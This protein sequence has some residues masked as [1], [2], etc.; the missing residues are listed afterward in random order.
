MLE[1]YKTNNGI[2]EKIDKPEKDAWINL[3]APTAEEIG[4]V[5]DNI[6]ME[7]TFIYAALDEEETSHIECE[8]GCTLV[9]VDIPY[10]ISDDEKSNSTKY[11]TVNYTTV[12]LGIILTPD[13]I[14]T[15]CLKENNI[16]N[17]FAD[18]KVKP[19][20]TNMKTRFLLQIMYKMSTRY[21]QYLK[22]IDKISNTLESGLNKSMQNQEL[23]KL[24]DLK[25]SLV[26]FSTSLKADEATIERIMRGRVIKM[27]DEDQDLVED[28]LIEIKQAIE[29]SSIYSNILSGT[30]EAFASIISN[31][32]NLVMKT[33]TSLTIIMAIPTIYASFYGM[34]VSAI[35]IPN[36]WFVV[37]V[38]ILTIAVVVIVLFRN[39]MF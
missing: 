32:L 38:S 10:H 23:I 8:D 19:L 5:L 29:M 31:N 27:Y 28:V 13:N 2:L 37:V 25:K 15:V 21:L 3:T 18:G 11:G 1:I 33:L 7:N 22:Q 34:N 6:E 35:P 24:L 16:I 26:F 4:T 17:D 39:R 12:P 30:M 20:Y 14:I 9:I 36:F